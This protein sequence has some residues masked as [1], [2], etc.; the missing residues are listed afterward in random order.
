[1]F[2]YNILIVLIVVISIFSCFET[3]NIDEQTSEEKRNISMMGQKDENI[4]QYVLKEFIFK[5][6]NF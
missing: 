4:K 1:M 3:T 6:F 5:I 2:K